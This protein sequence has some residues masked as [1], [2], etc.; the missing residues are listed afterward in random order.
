MFIITVQIIKITYKTFPPITQIFIL[1]E[2]N[3][4]TTSLLH[5]A[6]RNDKSRIFHVNRKSIAQSIGTTHTI[7]ETENRESIFNSLRWTHLEKLT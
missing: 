1:N 4:N 5:V 6:Q 3:P 7:F 2:I